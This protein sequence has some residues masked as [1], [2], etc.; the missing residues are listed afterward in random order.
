[1]ALTDWLDVI[2]NG[3]T[4]PVDI[5]RLR[6]V[7]TNI[8]RHLNSYDSSVEKKNIFG[9]IIAAIDKSNDVFS[10]SPEIAFIAADSVYHK[11]EGLKKESSPQENLGNV[12][13]VIDRFSKTNIL[14]DTSTYDESYAWVCGAYETRLKINYES[15]NIEDVLEDFKTINDI[16]LP[17][18]KKYSFDFY[19]HSKI[20]NVYHHTGKLL[21]EKDRFEEAKPILEYTSRWGKKEGSKLLARMYKE[22]LGVQVDNS[23]AKALETL[24]SKQSMKRFTIPIKDSGMEFPFHVYVYQKP[25]DYRYKG[26]DDQVEWL[27]Q[28]RGLTVPV[29]V[30]DSFRKLHKIAVEN[31]VSFPELADYAVGNKNKKEETTED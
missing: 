27:K 28:A 2:G 16:C 24:A 14:K 8:R 25:L 20:L 23:R 31:N 26:I 12:N 1:M 10:G 15:K 17:I 5:S 18:F 3:N 6:T 22:G 9:K 4:L 29:D 11:L 13:E 30:A 7:Y 19:L 21:F